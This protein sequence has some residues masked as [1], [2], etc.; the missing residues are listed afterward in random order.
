MTQSLGRIGAFDRATLDKGVSLELAREKRYAIGALSQGAA[1][2]TT[3]LIVLAHPSPLSFNAEWARR[4][5]AASE[6][7]GHR[8]LWTDLYGLGFEPAEAVRHHVLS[9]AG[10]PFDPL[11][12]Q[13]AASKAGTLP[14]DV[15]AEIDKLRS[16][17]QVIFHFPLWW[18]APPAILK[19]YFDRVFAHGALHDVKHRF[20]TG[21]CR[22]KRALFCV[23]TGSSAAE[24]G[25]GGKEGDIRMLLWPAAY[26]LRYLGF[27]VLEPVTVHGVHG[28]HRGA[29]ADAL[30][31]R[32]TEALARQDRLI[33]TFDD[34]PRM[35]FNADSEFD[36]E[37]RLK[38]G[39]ESHSPFI[40]H[41]S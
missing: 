9:R 18:F 30:H 3:T 40:R 22:G 8:V 19:G 33:A 25:P 2:V 21:H 31:T 41:P 16:A 5:R 11:K 1:K 35:R 6:R 36:A 14:R 29:R 23:T 37:G 4:S 20:D 17:E 27:D 10:A 12:A 32:L 7:L 39:R 28:H 26:T 38:P 13:E 15:S 34:L 24:S